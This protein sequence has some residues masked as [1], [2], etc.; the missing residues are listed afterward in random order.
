MLLLHAGCLVWG[1][2]SKYMSGPTRVF[3]DIIDCYGE[4][5]DQT[6]VF[7]CYQ[8]TSSRAEQSE[9]KLL[10]D[11]CFSRYLLQFSLGKI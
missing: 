1:R 10:F 9:S 8:A 6:H 3:N 4:F 11:C 2:M 7:L 5:P